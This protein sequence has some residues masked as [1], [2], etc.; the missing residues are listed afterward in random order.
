MRIWYVDDGNEGL[1]MVK[2]PSISSV[3]EV[4]P[5]NVC[6]MMYLYARDGLPYGECFRPA[7]GSFQRPGRRL[8]TARPREASC[9]NEMSRTG[10][11]VGQQ[12][13]GIGGLGL[14]HRV[15]GGRSEYQR[16]MAFSSSRP[17]KTAGIGESGK[18]VARDSLCALLS[19]TERSSKGDEAVEWRRVS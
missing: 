9:R 11:D 2:R 15:Q 12:G 14:R 4:Y 19:Q 1:A 7:S 18:G 3:R 16:W 6:S 17:K 5:C 8:G 13:D 10:A